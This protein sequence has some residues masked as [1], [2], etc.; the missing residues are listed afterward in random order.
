MVTELT[1]GYG[2]LAPLMLASALCI[3]L[4]RKYSLYEH[5]VENKFDSPAHLED[6]TI[7]VLEQLKVNDFFRP[8]RVTILDERITLKALTDIIANTNQLYFPVRD[9]EGNFSGILSIHSVRNWMFEENLFDL[10]VVR[11]LA[12]KPAYVRPDY[13]LYQ[14]LLRF[15]D[16]DYGQIPVLKEDSSD[17]IIGLIN[18]EDVFNAYAKAIKELRPEED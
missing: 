11:D 14:A 7:N 4:G 5:Q 13:D 17:E 2:L 6:T 10:V 8:E 15:V 18:R 12:T 9:S 1:Q 3:V 16:T